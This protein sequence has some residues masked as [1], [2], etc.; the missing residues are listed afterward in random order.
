MRDEQHGHSDQRRQRRTRVQPVRRAWHQQRRLNPAYLLHC[1]VGHPRGLRQ[2]DT[3]QR[4]CLPEEL[5]S[6]ASCEHVATA[7]AA[8]HRRNSLLRRKQRIQCSS[9][10]RA[11]REQQHLSSV[12]VCIRW[13]NYGLPKA[14]AQLLRPVHRARLE[15]VQPR[16][17][18]CNVHVL[19]QRRPIPKLYLSDCVGPV[20]PKH[21]DSVRQE[22][23]LRRRQQVLRE[24]SI[25]RPKVQLQCR[26]WRGERNLSTDAFCQ[27][28]EQQN[29]DGQQHTNV[30]HDRHAH[31]ITNK[32]SH[33]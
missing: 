20:Y 24:A 16:Q 25:P 12:D 27:C 23:S 11:Q 8:H 1:H 14:T 28:I 3:W 22:Q 15:P 32:H 4:H 19:R 31:S 18:H 26:R 29:A 2:L 17:L 7:N 30:K 21:V 33:I 10:H 9:H 13:H 5:P 6:H